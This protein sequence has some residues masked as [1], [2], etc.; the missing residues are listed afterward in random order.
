MPSCPSIPTPCSA[1]RPAC[2]VV[3]LHLAVVAA[4]AALLPRSGVSGSGMRVVLCLLAVEAVALG[5]SAPFLAARAGASG[6]GWVLLPLVAMAA[7]GFVLVAAAAWGAVPLAPL[8]SAHLFYLAFGW[9]LAALTMALRGLGTRA[10]AAQL[11]ATGVA[12]LMLGQVF[13]ANSLIEAAATQRSRMLLIDAVLWSNPWLIAAGSILEADP[14]RTQSLYEW[15]VAVY[16]GFQYPASSVP[17]AWVRGVVLALAYGCVG[18]VIQG[19]CWAIGRVR[20][21]PG[22]VHAVDTPCPG[23]RP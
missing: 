20:G 18:G 16:Y 17:T 21:R 6:I 3:G 23:N 14:L 11:A 4:A 1:W 8:A 2:A 10:A 19:T 9:L 13:A 7:L 15:S 5:V 12:L 22:N